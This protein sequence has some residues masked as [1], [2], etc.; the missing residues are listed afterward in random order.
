MTRSL[1]L[2]YRMGLS[3][4][5]GRQ[6]I[7]IPNWNEFVSITKSHLPEIVKFTAIGAGAPAEDQARDQR[8]LSSAQMAMQ[9]DQAAQAAGQPSSMDP[10][11][12]VRQILE[13]G[14]WTDVDD[15]LTQGDPAA[16][17]T[18]APLPEGQV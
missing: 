18:A 8:Q 16:G 6:T 1:D 9:V 15:I 14:G 4:M 13:K 11:A 10:A 5:R 7:Y 12:L 17:G 2:E 3:T